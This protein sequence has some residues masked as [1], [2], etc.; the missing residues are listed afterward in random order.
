MLCKPWVTGRINSVEP[1]NGD[2]FY[3][4][5][6]FSSKS[7]RLLRIV[8]A[9]YPGLADLALG[10]ATAAAS[11][12]VE[13]LQATGS[14]N[15]RSLR[16]L[17]TN[18]IE[19]TRGMSDARTVVRFA[20]S[21]MPASLP[22]SQIYTTRHQAG[23]RMIWGCRPLRG[24]RLRLDCDSWAHRPRLYADVRFTDYGRSISAV[25]GGTAGNRPGGS[26][27]S[28]QGCGQEATILVLSDYFDA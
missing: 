16:F 13:L 8:S 9:G 6:Y 14:V 1:R 10:L 26:P 21:Y 18:E 24:L 25:P 15:E 17:I 11:Q 27:R 7:P 19:S 4:Q 3:L 2:V 28:V 5:R 20:D 22:G 12:L 23:V